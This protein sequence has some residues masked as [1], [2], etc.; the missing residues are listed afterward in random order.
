[1]LLHWLNSGRYKWFPLGSSVSG[2]TKFTER[3]K[4]DAVSFDREELKKLREMPSGYFKMLSDALD[5][6]LAERSDISRDIKG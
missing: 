2:V 3:L 1:M 6:G 5:K 4:P